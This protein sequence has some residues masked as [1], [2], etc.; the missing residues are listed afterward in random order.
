MKILTLIL[1]ALVACS[2][3]P[4]APPEE[5]PDNNLCITWQSQFW[6]E[7]TIRVLDSENNPIVFEQIHVPSGGWGTYVEPGEYLVSFTITCDDLIE[8]NEYPGHGSITAYPGSYYNFS[9]I[10]TYYGAHF[11][12]GYIPIEVY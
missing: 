2:H 7:V 8:G 4:I 9:F 5:E 10:L 11:S 3:N 1:L 12:T 6:A